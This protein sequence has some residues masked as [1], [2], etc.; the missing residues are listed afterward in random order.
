MI[1]PSGNI[2]IAWFA[3]LP[4]NDRDDTVL[5]DFVDYFAAIH[6]IQ[7]YSFVY[8]DVFCSEAVARVGAAHQRCA[9]SLLRDLAHR[10]QTGDKEI[11]G[12][13]DSQVPSLQF[14]GF[15]YAVYA[16]AGI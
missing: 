14:G 15:A 5:S 11:S 7:I 6:D 8:S 1:A 16:A 3:L 12:S 13:I 4:C 2:D 10:V 9:F